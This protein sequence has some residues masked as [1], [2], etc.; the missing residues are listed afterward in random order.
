MENQYD[1]KKLFEAAKELLD[2]PQCPKVRECRNSINNKNGLLCEHPNFW[3]D[4]L[5]EKIK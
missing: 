4:V 1:Y 2:C 3:E 5:L